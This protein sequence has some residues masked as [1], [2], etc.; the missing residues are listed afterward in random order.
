MKK[1]KKSLWLSGISMLLCAV[2]LVGATFAWFTDSV[3]NKGNKIESG[4]MDIR[5]NGFSWSA[6][7]D[8]WDV[9]KPNYNLKQPVISETKWE[10]GQYNAVV[11]LVS[12]Y[13]STLAADIGLDFEITENGKNLADALWYKLT[14]IGAKDGVISAHVNQAVPKDKLSFA[15]PKNR[16]TTEADGVTTMSKI[17]NDATEAL[18]VYT[19]YHRGQYAYYLLEYGMYTSAGNEY[20]NGSF[21]LTVTVNAKQATVETDGFG[22][23]DYDKDALFPVRN[24][25]DFA[26]GLQNG[27]AVS[28]SDDF[29]WNSAVAMTESTESVLNLEK[30]A[31]VTVTGAGIIDL[32]GSSQLTMQGA[33]ALKQDMDS[34]LGYLVRATDD[35]KVI[36][37][38]GTFI[39]GL[40]C[41]QAD[42]NAQ[43]EI[44]G[45]HFEALVDWNDT[46]WLLN[47]VDNT[48]ASI[49]VYGGT[50]VNYDP[51]KSATENPAANFV[52]DG[53]RVVSEKQKNGDIWYTVI[54]E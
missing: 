3:A 8:A 45:G 38:D 26:E 18:R 10:P 23:S 6:T 16:P 30:G 15:D 25:K 13:N 43:V 35:S 21:N 46:Y 47:L 17:E 4:K 12:N 36:I 1:T 49:K 11:L 50:F 33:G 34:E 32:K 41:V 22:S 31:E 29:V 42:K 20:M 19:D 52:A 14:P 9:K 2:M 54:P 51:S 53:Y 27:G 40:T 24:S 39:G 5:V 44:Y 37:K 28:V 48:N 7:A